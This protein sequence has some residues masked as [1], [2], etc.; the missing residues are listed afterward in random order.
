GPGNVTS[1]LVSTGRSL[2]PLA[3]SSIGLARS[4]LRLSLPFSSP[5][6]SLNH[7]LTPR[8]A[9]AFGRV[10]LE[11]VKRIKNAFGVTINDVVL[12]ACTLA[13]RDHLRA[14]GEHPKRAI[15]A[16]VPVSGHANGD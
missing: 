4:A 15:I 11:S 14:R 16:T 9:V 8:R 3:R 5:R 7:A 13:L 10:S 2:M 12:A 1:A 6:T